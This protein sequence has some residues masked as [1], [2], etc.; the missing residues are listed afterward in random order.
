MRWLRTAGIAATL[1]L[2]GS[3]VA[4]AQAAGQDPDPKLVAGTWRSQSGA[5]VRFDA[6][7]RFA[8]TID[9][10][11]LTGGWTFQPRR[12]NV[13]CLVARDG[14]G[15]ERGGCQPATLTGKPGDT[16]TIF[17]TAYKRVD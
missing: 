4:R 9:G 5:T 15:T 1:L 17:G 2:I 3:S 16:I 10:K 6:N 12:T 7:G 13:V 14:S 11:E 8:G